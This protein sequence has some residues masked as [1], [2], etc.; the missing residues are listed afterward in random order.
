MGIP[1]KMESTV[2]IRI[3]GTRLTKC[4]KLVVDMKQDGIFAR[5]YPPVVLNDDSIAFTIPEEDAAML[6]FTKPLTWQIRGRDENGASIY[7][8]K[9]R[10]RVDEIIGGSDW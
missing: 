8:I 6:D 3:H 1:Q 10:E 5:S 7:N 4:K 2:K 9:K